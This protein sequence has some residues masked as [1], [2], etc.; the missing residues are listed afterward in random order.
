[1]ANATPWTY[2]RLDAFGNY[3]DTAGIYRFAVN[4]V[5]SDQTAGDDEGERDNTG[6][7]P[8][9]GTKN[10]P[11]VV[12]GPADDV[13]VQI[14]TAPLPALSSPSPLVTL[15]GG[16]PVRESQGKAGSDNKEDTAVLG[17]KSQEGTRLADTAVLGVE[18][19]NN[20]FLGLTWL[21][22]LGIASALT[23][24]WLILAAIIRRIRGTEI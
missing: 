9:G 2:L 18:D 14:F 22:W 23:V 15:Y 13:S 21:S 5:A 12:P 11:E 20:T 6:Q 1:A 24:G 3:D 4:N 7:A 10:E 17:T 16:T 19:K 8:F